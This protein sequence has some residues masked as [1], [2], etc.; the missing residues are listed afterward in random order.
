MGRLILLGWVYPISLKS[1]TPMPCGFLCLAP[2]CPRE[3]GWVLEQEAG[4]VGGMSLVPM[5]LLTVWPALM[6]I[7]A[8]HGLLFS[9][10]LIYLFFLAWQ[11][12]MVWGMCDLGSEHRGDK[13]PCWILCG[14]PTAA[15]LVAPAGPCYQCEPSVP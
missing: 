7:R 6:L 2:N 15:A 13:S 8:A 14:H 11:L 4:R 3:L 1:H 9:V 10:I 12:I 5:A